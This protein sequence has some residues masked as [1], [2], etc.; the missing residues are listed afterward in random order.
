MEPQKTEKEMLNKVLTAASKVKPSDR[1]PYAFE[2]RI[3]A[4]IAEEPVAGTLLA[5]SQS[6]WRAVAPCLALVALVVIWQAGL[7]VEAP[8]PA[9]NTTAQPAEDAT[10]EEVEDLM[11]IALETLED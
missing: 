3:R 8:A 10:I 1:V 9:P 2:Q 4:Q 6:L 7:P 11:Q 5:W